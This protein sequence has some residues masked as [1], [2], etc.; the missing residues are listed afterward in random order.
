M[1]KNDKNDKNNKNTFPP[2]L[3][4]SIG[5]S[6]GLCIASVTGGAK[7]LPLGVAIG[8]AVGSGI[9]AIAYHLQKK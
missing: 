3:F 6:L 2:V 1:S 7:A 8:A 9:A 5:M 4:I